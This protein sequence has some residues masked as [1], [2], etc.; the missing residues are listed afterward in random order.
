VHDRSST[1]YAS[2]ASAVSRLLS[3]A[4]EA[5]DKTVPNRIAEYF[6]ARVF[7]GDLPAGSKLPPD[8]EL[9]AELGVD[10]T[11]LRMAMQQLARMGLVRAV[12]GSG[13]HVLDYREHAG[14]DF[15]AVIFELSEVSLGSAFL[16]QALDDWIDVMPV[17]VGRALV[18][19]TRDD[20]RALD[21][22]LEAQLELLA[23]RKALAPIVALE[24][25]LQD[26]IAR[27]LGNTTLM[28]LG[29]SSRPLRRK[30]VALYFEETD[31]R[32]HVL[33]QRQFLVAAAQS[34]ADAGQI[35]ETYRAYLRSRTEP[36]RRR[37]QALPVSPT[38]VSRRRR[39]F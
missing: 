32:A 14:L 26:R 12:R 39:K 22:L 24:L 29:N 30:L 36:L 16:L 33:A 38:L 5:A 11:S 20:Q 34:Q 6:L 8:R 10:R 15:L 27:L 1:S 28:L 19:A 9:A 25:D 21:G 17:V 13:V 23:G 3:A 31:V 2:T 18:R 4:A 37:L 7:T 35:A